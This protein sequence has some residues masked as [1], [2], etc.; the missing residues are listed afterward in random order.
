M[1]PRNHPSIFHASGK[2]FNQ[3]LSTFCAA[4]G[5]SSTS[6]KFVSSS[7]TFHQL[8][9]TFCAAAVTSINFPFT[10]RTNLLSTS[11]DFPCICMIDYKIA[12][13]F[14][15]AGGPPV[16]FTSYRLNFCQ[17]SLRP[18]DLSNSFHFPLLLSSSSSS[19]VSYPKLMKYSPMILFISITQ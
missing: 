13:T 8:Y 9:S 14:R 12:S 6:V 1:R 2:V 16:N 3:L 17:L 11:V 10:H 5:I 4:A 18:R 19:R 7:W 15:E